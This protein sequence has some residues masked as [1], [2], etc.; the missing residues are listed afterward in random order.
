MNITG[1]IKVR[2]RSGAGGKDTRL[3][4]R[5]KVTYNCG[6]CRNT[7]YDY[8]IYCPQCLGEVMPLHPAPSVLT[9]MSVPPGKTVEIATLLAALTG[10]KNFAFQKALE[11]LPWIMIRGTEDCVLRQWKE[12]L[13][14]EKVEVEIVAGGPPAKRGWRGKAS[15]YT[16]EAP[17]PRFLNETTTGGVR[18]VARSLKDPLLRMK[19]VE[20]VLAGFRIIEDFY[21]R[22]PTHR[23]LFSDFLFQI[24]QALQ[25]AVKDYDSV[26]QSSEAGMRSRIEK[27]REAFDAMAAEIQEVLQRVEERL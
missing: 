22:N 15:V 16:S 17:A 14:A 4:V 5:E 23:V 8:H 12:V 19:W 26:F 24:D 6:S 9:V 18:R 2:L 21:K 11:S 3:S 20:T 25:E 10:V 7:Y 27:T 13:D 1:K